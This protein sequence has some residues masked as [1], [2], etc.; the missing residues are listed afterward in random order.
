MRNEHRMVKE[1]T[2]RL[3]PEMRNS[4]VEAFEKELLKRVVGQDRAVQK[5]VQ[6]YQVFKAG[7][8][9][10]DRPLA[11]LLLLGPTG[12]GKTHVAETA[13]EIL[14]GSR[15]ALLKVD[16]AEFQHSHEVSKLIGSP[17]GYLGHRESPAALSQENVNRFRTPENDFSLVLF[18]EIEKASEALWQLLLGI[19]DRGNLTLGDNRR[20]DFSRVIIL[21]TSNLGAKEMSQLI[22]GS[23]GFAPARQAEEPSL[24][25][26]QKIYR[27]AV[28]ACKKKFS[29]EFM[30]RLDSIIV[31]QSL[32]PED[33]RRILDLELC[34]IQSRIRQ[35]SDGKFVLNCTEAAR[36]ALLSEGVDANYGARHLKRVLERR[37]VVPAANLLASGQLASQ[38]RLIVDYMAPNVWTYS[39]PARAWEWT[40]T[41]KTE[42]ACAGAAAA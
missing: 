5:L 26:D 27:V 9:S 28:Q 19:L 7:L 35:S 1:H 4:E 23:M 39:K 36:K 6:T 14:F 2:V 34:A 11:S 30:N 41:E 13:A 24:D 18:D 38:E 20:V 15:S 40:S 3:N 37:V 17:P 33:F 31:F 8:A 29:P 42:V 12:S 21:M 10:P 22:E 25:L 32:R 16:C